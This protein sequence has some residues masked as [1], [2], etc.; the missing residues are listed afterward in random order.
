VLRKTERRAYSATNVY[1]LSGR[2]VSPCGKRYVGFTTHPERGR[3]MRCSGKKHA[4]RCNCHQ[5]RARDLELRVW[6]AVY[7]LLTD[8]E[9][10]LALAPGGE[11]A[12]RDAG[13]A[14]K[15]IARID[16]LIAQKEKAITDR[17]AEALVAG[18]AP[19]VIAK[20]VAQIEDDLTV[21][22]DQRAEM[23]CW[24]SETVESEARKERLRYFVKLAQVL[25]NPPLEVMHEVYRLLDVEVELGE[26]L[27]QPMITVRGKLTT[28]AIDQIGRRARDLSGI[29][30]RRARDRGRAGS[31]ART[32]CARA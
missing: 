7:E 26:N 19:E 16:S 28:E 24:H 27:A 15:E 25:M 23:S 5:Q 9:R 20:A 14:A 11:Q 2:V 32:P 4:P 29:A 18:L 12:A 1:P 6:E 17:A 22:R 3:L 8:E 10:L 31:G 13:A 21:L 30:S